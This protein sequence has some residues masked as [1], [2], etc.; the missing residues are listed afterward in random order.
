M[1]GKIRLSD[2]VCNDCWQ[3]IPMR[4]RRDLTRAW[5]TWAGDGFGD[6]NV[7]VVYEQAVAAVIAYARTKLPPVQD[8]QRGLT[9]AAAIIHSVGGGR[10]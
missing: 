2:L 8:D 5:D 10:A 7:R 4:L 6:P 1:S 9:N 3:R